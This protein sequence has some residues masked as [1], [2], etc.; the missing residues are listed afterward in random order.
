MES[1]L[2]RYDS[3]ERARIDAQKEWLKSSAWDALTQYQPEKAGGKLPVP[4][5]KKIGRAALDSR[6]WSK[7]L[8][9][10]HKA[11]HE[12]RDREAG[13]YAAKEHEQ[14]Q[15]AER[16][17][18]ARQ[19]EERALK[20]Q[21]EAA[22]REAA[23]Q[24][25]EERRT[26]KAL[27]EAMDVYRARKLKQQKGERVQEASERAFN[28]KLTKLEDI[29]AAAETGGY[30][31][32]KRQV[33]WEGKPLT[34]YATH[35]YPFAAL[36]HA[37]DFKGRGEASNMHRR[38]AGVAKILQDDPSIWAAPRNSQENY[39]NSGADAKSNAISTSYVNTEGNYGTLGS[40]AL[41]KGDSAAL[42]YGF[43]HVR[44]DS[45]LQVSV[46]DGATDNGAG[47]G[48]T[49]VSKHDPYTP[50]MLDSPNRG[51]LYNEVQIRRYGE[52]GKP[53]LPD[54]VIT[55]DGNAS[56]TIKQHAA[57]FDIPIVNLETKYYKEKEAARLE[58]LM[59]GI[60]EESAYPEVKKVLDAINASH[61]TLFHGDQ[62]AYIGGG[63]EPQTQ[64]RFYYNQ[65]LTDKIGDFDKLEMAKRVDFIRDRLQG[66]AEQIRA[67]T[68]KGERYTDFHHGMG[69]VEIRNYGEGWSG[70]TMHRIDVGL[71]VSPDEYYQK[72]EIAD[73]GH[74]SPDSPGA[75]RGATSQY[76][77]EVL[78]AAQAY[79][80]AK[81]QNEQRW[82]ENRRAQNVA[83]SA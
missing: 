68:A 76:Y 25:E 24:A 58:G 81:A 11:S 12:Q 48:K 43:D 38:G 74:P 9:G 8:P 65:E 2:K 64:K 60:N 44:P 75:R 1:V 57:F 16:D 22:E 78:P 67:A 17:E 31:V 6:V 73:G 32:E 5:L 63:D 20:L 28:E 27:L 13:Y 4:A 82:N 30:G 79:L 26:Q 3:D 42:L 66:Q 37:I 51:S 47:E 70:E 45:I 50:E 7:I 18:M 71:K 80:E 40:A 21:Q 46:G 14:E 53:Q 23:R 54:Y 52:D 15:Q 39:G 49:A 19:D 36:Q 55:F 10:L 41:T 62:N 33:E 59:D 56:D 69:P 61:I 29:D 34:V 72:T 77:D 83:K 35:G